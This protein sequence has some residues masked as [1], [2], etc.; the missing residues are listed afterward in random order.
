[1]PKPKKLRADSKFAAL[2]ETER[3]ELD[4]LLLHGGTL[5]SAVEWMAAHGIDTSLQSVSEYYR[6]H[7]LPVRHERMAAVAKIINGVKTEGVE[8]AARRQVAVR[9]FELLTDPDADQ[10]AAAAMV[11]LMLQGQQTAND[12]RRLEL[13]EKKAKQLDDARAALE[14]RKAGGGLTA[15]AL[16]EIENAL[17][18]M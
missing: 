5:E 16:A 10:K 3:V 8:A 9:A 15:E 18:L 11:K 1:M 7:V 12:A 4:S 13:L 2:S 6:R 17:N 14:Q